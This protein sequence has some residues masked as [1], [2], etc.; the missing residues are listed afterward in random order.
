MQ[1]P[2]EKIVDIRALGNDHQ[3]RRAAVE[4]VHGMEGGAAPPERGER[5]CHG[6]ALPAGRAV[7]RHVRALIQ[8]GKVLVFINEHQGRCDGRRGVFAVFVADLH[9]QHVA[10]TDERVGEHPLAVSHKSRFAQLEPGDQP[11][12][13]MELCPQD[14]LYGAAV[15]RFVYGERQCPHTPVFL[16]SPSSFRFLF[17]EHMV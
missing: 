4:S 3:P 15:P 13:H 12:R 16:L 5:V 7:Y 11:L 10:G 9:A 17:A 2:A 14:V 6:A 1:R 8:N